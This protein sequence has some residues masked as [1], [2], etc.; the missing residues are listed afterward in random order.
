MARSNKRP[1]IDMEEIAPNR[2]LLHNEHVRGFVKGEGEV[3]GRIFTLTT[4]RRDGLIARLRERTFRVQTLLD[5]ID[6]LPAPPSPIPLGG[7]GRR[8]IGSSLDRYSVFDARELTWKPIEPE[9]RDGEPE[10][11]IRDGSV[12]RRRKGRGAATYALAFAERSGV[13]GLRPLGETAA[14]LMG[15]AQAGMR[16]TPRLT[17]QRHD[18]GYIFPDLQLPPAYR[19]VLNRI[20][21][22]TDDGWLTN[23]QGWQLAQ[24]LFARLGLRLELAK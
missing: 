1:T 10:L 6:A 19:A 5:Q 22:R 12:I 7:I 15:Y 11:L 2:F 23:T 24:E 16:T 18:D 21:T 4:W 3:E 20:A 13:I 8:P 14:L 17:A 9:T